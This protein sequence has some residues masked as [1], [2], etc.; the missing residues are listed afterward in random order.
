MTFSQVGNSE[1]NLSSALPRPEMKFIF[2][3]LDIFPNQKADIPLSIS[4]SIILS[5]I[6]IPGEIT[7]KVTFLKNRILFL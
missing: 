3:I 2:H 4:L 7:R 6:F 5:I 1:S